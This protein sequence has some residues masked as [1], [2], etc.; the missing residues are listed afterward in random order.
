M[1]L[2]FVSAG[3]A[4]GL[5]AK[6]SREAGLEVA[7]SF[8]AVGA[9]MEKFRAGEPCDVVILTQ[10][11]IAELAAE[12]RVDA[13]TCSDLGSVPTAIAVRA[14]DP[15]PD[16]SGER[17]LRIALLQADAIYFPDPTKATA[18]IHFAKV[19]QSLGIH[20][21][22]AENFRTFPNGTTAMKAMAEAEG[23]PIGCTQATEILATSG[24]RL[25]APLP[26]GFDLE[27]VYTAAVSSTSS[28][29]EIAAKFVERLAGEIAR[30]VRNAAGFRD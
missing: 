21:Q 30:A 17:A 26:A 7:G 22:V 19:V 9:M 16:V 28:H 2:N 12:G 20:A 13:R 6:L 10:R 15:T 25:V 23:H 3:A 4:Q 5:V 18:G 14:S 29:P 24:V 11:Q 27:T 8:G 1:Q